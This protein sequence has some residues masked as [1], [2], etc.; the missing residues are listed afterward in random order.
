[1][2]EAARSVMRDYP[3]IKLAYGESDEYSFVLHK[4]TNLYGRRTSKLIST[5]TSCFTGNYVRLWS[6]FLGDQQLQYTPVFDGR[7]VCYPTLAILRDYLSWR[8]ADTHINNQYNTCYWCLVKS[9]KTPADA[10]ATL[11]GTDTAAKNEL[12]FGHF[13]INYAHLPEQFRKGSV[14]IRRPV[15]KVVKYR[16][17]GTA[18]ERDRLEECVLHCDIIGDAFWKQYGPSLDMVT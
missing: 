18:V 2:D 17:D 8:Q 12:L 15:R 10:Q 3:E 13:G 9:G 7:A 5:I 16:E 1:M 4:D 11:K 6:Q 14:V